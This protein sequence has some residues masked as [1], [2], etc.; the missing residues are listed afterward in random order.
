MMPYDHC[1]RCAPPAI[2]HRS[3]TTTLTQTAPNFSFTSTISHFFIQA[4]L[5][6]IISFNNYT[7]MWHCNSSTS[8]GITLINSLRYRKE[9][10][11]HKYLRQE[12]ATPKMLLPFTLKLEIIFIVVIERGEP[13]PNSCAAQVQRVAVVGPSQLTSEKCQVSQP[14]C[15][16]PKVCT[17][18]NRNPKIAQKSKPR[19][20]P[21]TSSLGRALLL[22]RRALATFSNSAM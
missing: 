12:G 21:E 11:E 14:G 10:Y 7:I 19:P 22:L 1:G 16:L 17:F 2:F 15:S 18:P 5:Y 4:L 6:S 13:C 3:G 20:C 9:Q 8:S